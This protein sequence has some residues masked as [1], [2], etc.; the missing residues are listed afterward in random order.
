MLF[1]VFIVKRQILLYVKQYL[2]VVNDNLSVSCL[3]SFTCD[4][5]L[6]CVEKLSDIAT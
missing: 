1:S 4:N 5:K 6:K 2:V 3:I